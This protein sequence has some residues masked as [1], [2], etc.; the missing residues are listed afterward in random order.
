MKRLI[1]LNIL[2]F[3]GVF[4]LL[5]LSYGTFHYFSIIFFFSFSISS[6]IF[7]LGILF[8]LIWSRFCNANFSYH[9]CISYVYFFKQ[10]YLNNSSSSWNLV[11]VF[12]FIFLITLFS[13]AVLLVALL[14][15]NL[16]TCV[17]P[18]PICAY[19]H[20]GCQL[21]SLANLFDRVIQH[22]ARMHGLSSDLHSELVSS[23][24]PFY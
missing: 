16:C 6:K 15:L 13:V 19:G 12:F 11:A 10:I 3:F 18:M 9:A 21:V 8:S 5:S 14:C 23:S 2:F 4:K 7:F 22:S 17:S 24:T 1:V 20:A